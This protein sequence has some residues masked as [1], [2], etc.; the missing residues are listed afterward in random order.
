MPGDSVKV[1][2]RVRPFNQVTSF[3]L[4]FFHFNSYMSFK[5]QKKIQSTWRKYPA[6][7][8]LQ[9]ILNML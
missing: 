7:K 1:A 8:F 5:D 3:W 9:K 4:L 6:I 2:V